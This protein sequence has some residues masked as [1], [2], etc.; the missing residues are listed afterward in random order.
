MPTKIDDITVSS[1]DEGH[2][3]KTRQKAFSRNGLLL[4]D[5]AVLRAMESNLEEKYIP[6]KMTKSGALSPKNALA[7]M[8]RMGELLE[9]TKTVISELCDSLQSGDAKACPLEVTSVSLP[10]DYC[11]ARVI[12]RKY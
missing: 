7:S 3:E 12:C 5:E 4:E 11:T 8:E 1:F 10:C 2:V 9:E 6:V